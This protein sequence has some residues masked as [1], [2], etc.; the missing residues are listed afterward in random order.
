VITPTP[1]LDARAL[2]AFYIVTN[3]SFSIVWRVLHRSKSHLRPSGGQKPGA[4]GVSFG[5]LSS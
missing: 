4:G 3:V 2:L 1:L 5:P